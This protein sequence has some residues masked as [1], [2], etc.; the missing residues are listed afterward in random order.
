MP[1]ALAGCSRGGLR[2]RF[3]AGDRHYYHVINR[4][5]VR[6]GD[7][8][9]TL[10]SE[11]DLLVR[12]TG[13]RGRWAD[14]RAGLY[15]ARSTMENPRESRD[16]PMPPDQDWPVLADMRSGLPVASAVSTRLHFQPADGRPASWIT[17]VSETDRS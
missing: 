8:S 1:V 16:R 7:R 3:R 14:I 5:E 11:Y 6:R 13:A 4:L 15:N 17:L 12:A 9:A 10:T 2:Y